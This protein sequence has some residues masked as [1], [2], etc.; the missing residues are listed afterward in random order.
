MRSVALTCLKDFVQRIEEGQQALPKEEIKGEPNSSAQALIS[1][2]TMLGW[3]I[4]SLSS[5]VL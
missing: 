1:D 3:A 2:N 4:N 5:K